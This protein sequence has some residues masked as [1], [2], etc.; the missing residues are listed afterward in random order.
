MCII[1]LRSSCCV[2][3]HSFEEQDKYQ[4]AI[5][6]YERAIEIRNEIKEEPNES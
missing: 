4:K 5:D 1:C 6:A 3:F 2:S